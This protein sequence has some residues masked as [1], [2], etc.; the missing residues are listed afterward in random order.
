VNLGGEL[1]TGREAGAGS[2]RPADVIPAVR[3]EGPKTEASLSLAA[4]V[5]LWDFD[6]G[7]LAYD[8]LCVF[9]ALLL[10]L[11]PALWWGDP[12]APRP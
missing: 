3:V 8:L 10:L 9:L 1:G 2:L 4:R 5:L 11:V 12:M 6:R 7:S